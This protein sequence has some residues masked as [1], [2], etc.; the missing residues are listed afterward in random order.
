VYTGQ[1]SRTA[2]AAATYRAVHQ[3]LENG[4]IFTDPLALR[5]L[6]EN[7]EAIMRDAEGEPWRRPMRLFIAAR[8]RFAED[9]LAS[10]VEKRGTRQLV[11]LGA[12]L[13]TFAYRN[14]FADRLRV[15]EVD[16]PA[17]Q[18]WKR[19]RLAA[20]DIP[21]PSS[22][23]FTPVDFE[24]QTLSE[25]LAHAYFDL[26]L[27]TFFTWLGVIPYLTEDAIVST[28]RF[29]ASLP[30]RTHV[31]FDYADPPE[32]LSPEVRAYHDRRAA[33][34]AEIGEKW[35]TYFEADK[36]HPRLLALGFTQVEDLG[37][38]QLAARYYPERLNQGPVHNR[39]GHV[40][41]ASKSERSE[42]NEPCSGN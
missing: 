37:P 25:A 38:P 12:G 19:E 1:P 26:S 29:I 10:A 15:F 16:H 34:V 6:D 36:L 11:V 32:T 28:L 24:R 41:V 39:G 35:L 23:T 40:L 8:T 5:I 4:S 22:L 33:C 13:D 20:A 31:V 27:P 17:T 9:A 30:S 21:I 3:L 18:A 7:A 42:N 2:L 14:P